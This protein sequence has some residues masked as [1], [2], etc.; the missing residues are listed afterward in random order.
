MSARLVLAG[1]ALAAAVFPVAGCRRRPPPPP[2]ESAD[3][4]NAAFLATDTLVFDDFSSRVRWAGVGFTDVRFSKMRGEVVLTGEALTGMTLVLDAASLVQ[5]SALRSSSDPASAA[6]LD[7]ARHPEVV[8]R[9][10]AARPDTTGGS[11]AALLD[12]KLTLWGETRPLTV[13]ASV[14]ITATPVGT[15]VR[16]SVAINASF[17]LTSAQWDST[18]AHR[19][20]PIEVRATLIARPRDAS[21]PGGSIRAMQRYQ[22]SLRSIPGGAADSIPID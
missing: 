4:T 2:P 20:G 10:D 9:L 7:A 14:R 17:V 18:G 1:I 6:F 22:D 11:S 8:F 5:M 3:S 19:T 15:E 12:G 13:P 21:A 16:R